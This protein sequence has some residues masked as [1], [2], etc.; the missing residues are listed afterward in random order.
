MNNCKIKSKKLCL[1]NECEICLKK[2]LANYNGKT[3]IGNLKYKCLND[4]KITARNIFYS[5]NKKYEFKCDICNHIFDIT[6]NHLTSK[7]PKWCPYC[8]SRKLCNDL[9]CKHCFENSFANFKEKTQNGKLKIEC[10]EDDIDPRFIFKCSVKKYK[11]KCDICYHCFNMT[12]NN[13]KAKKA[14]KAL[15]L[16]NFI[17]F[18]N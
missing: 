16:I 5:S 11:F 3:K 4:D 14:K 12:I 7:N 1:N 10:L 8:S 17:F 13:I 9:E 18:F 15:T 6:I 2:S